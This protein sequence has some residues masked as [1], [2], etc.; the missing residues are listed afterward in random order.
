MDVIEIQIGGGTLGYIFIAAG[1]YSGISTRSE[2]IASLAREIKD[3]DLGYAG[4]KSRERL[5]EYLSSAVFDSAEERSDYSIA[6]DNDKIIA[7]AKEVLGKCIVA[8]PSHPI[9]I[10]V[11]PT[12]S[13]FVENNMYGTTGYTPWQQ[14]MLVFINPRNTCWQNALEGTIAHEYN[15]TVFLTHRQCNSLVD[16]LIFEGLAEHFREQVLHS[17]HAPWT[18][19]LNEN[20][21]RKVLAKLSE[22]HS[23][24]SIDQNLRK[25]VFFGNDK[26]ALWSG[27]SIGYQIVMSFLQENP[28]MAWPEIMAVPPKEIFNCFDF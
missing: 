21:A 3:S 7:I 20:E 6:L 2:F 24:E 27:Y 13:S 11:F 23:I 15:H 5:A 28:R 26:Y 12:F 9:H 16:S 19:V 8:L 18:Q 25:A 17:G 1:K 10:F 4:F 14:T 22:N